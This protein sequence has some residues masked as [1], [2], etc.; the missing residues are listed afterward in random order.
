MFVNFCAFAQIGK[1]AQ[2]TL[3]ITVEDMVD[4]L[5]ED[6]ESPLLEI[7]DNALQPLFSSLSDKPNIIFR[8][9]VKRKIPKSLGYTDKLY[10]GNPF[11]SY[12]R[13]R[14]E[15]NRIESGTL[16]EKDPGEKKINDFTSWFIQFKSFGFIN[17]FIIGDYY[18]EV[19]QGLSFWKYYSIGKNSNIESILRR[20][21]EIIYANS[22]DELGF[23]RGIAVNLDFKILNTLL[24]YSNRNLTAS[25]DS[26]ENI[27]YFTTHYFNTS[28]SLSRKN[29]TNEKVYGLR[30]YKG[31]E[32]YKLGISLFR[33]KYS[34]NYLIIGAKDIKNMSLDYWFCI[35]QIN[36]SGELFY[37]SFAK[38][39]FVNLIN[40]K[41]SSTV[42]FVVLYRYY[43]PKNV[44][45][46]SNPF[47]DASGGNNEEGFFIGLH[48]KINQ[49][50]QISCY[51]DKFVNPR[52]RD[53]LFSKNSSD[54]L[55]QFKSQIKKKSIV[56]I[57][58][59]FR[60]YEDNSKVTHLGRVGVLNDVYRK[61]NLR[62]HLDYKMLNNLDYQF[63]FEYLRLYTELLQ[64]SEYG[65]LYYHDVGVK[66]WSE[67][68]IR[69]R[70][71]VFNTTSYNSRVSVYEPDLPGV[72]TIPI[73][74]GRGIKWYILFHYSYRDRIQC[75][76][77]YS[78]LVREDVRKIGS[79][80][81]QMPSN[82]VAYLGFQ[83]DVYL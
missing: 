74:Y 35:N 41:M 55:F 79:G 3:F 58:Y 27:K 44:N 42:N 34:R 71:A 6:E 10:L 15:S 16:I 61:D 78:Y 21:R 28:A 18:F 19:G 67:L 17:K 83:L 70:V 66:L 81:D 69:F 59:R 24:F 73:L 56:T 72:L 62:M 48:W 37:N 76:L 75:S 63:R 13:I 40:F 7:E 47:G 29:N 5:K 80:L 1:D 8:S 14:I 26:L 57:R 33:S 53:L 65:R 31:S 38:L 11:S 9:R 22:S 43:S 45:R 64:M 82:F 49:R 20:G 23:M 2:D 46:F 54:Y 30:F 51:S 32:I 12:H 68:R 77:K 60:S 4:E 25:L 50:T 52:V 36:L 39:N